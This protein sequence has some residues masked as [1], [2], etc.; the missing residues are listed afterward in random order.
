LKLQNG[1]RQCVVQGE[2]PRPIWQGRCHGWGPREG[3]RLRET[4]D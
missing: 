4:P 1:N 3:N 2:P